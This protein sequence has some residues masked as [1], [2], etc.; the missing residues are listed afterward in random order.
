MANKTNI[1]DSVALVTGA[2]SGIGRACCL[3]LAR[4]GCHIGAVARSQDVARFPPWPRARA[5]NSGVC[6]R[7]SC[8]VVP[9][10][11][12]EVVEECR[13]LGVNA[14]AITA[15]LSSADGAQSAIDAC[16]QK[17]G[18]LNILVNAGLS[19]PRCR[20]RFHL[21]N[22]HSFFHAAGM[23]GGTEQPLDDWE[24]CIN[25]NLMSLM[26]LTNLAVPHLEK[27]GT[28]R[29]HQPSLPFAID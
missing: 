12:K 15:D 9:Q 27:K 26:R 29:A 6:C 17:L 2:S 3:E 4:K 8:R 28:H 25:I 19:P 20:F 16:V 18:G 11:L 1:K 23:W 21:H 13:K 10:K 24:K 5:I 7:V 14:A 22:S